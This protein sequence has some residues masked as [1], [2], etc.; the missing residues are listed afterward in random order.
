M[1]ELLIFPRLWIINEKLGLDGSEQFEASKEW[2]SINYSEMQTRGMPWGYDQLLF[3]VEI[4]ACHVA[5]HLFAFVHVGEGQKWE[6][7]TSHFRATTE[8]VWSEER[9]SSTW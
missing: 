4:R 8:W 9:R 2:K 1:F 7:Q 3:A 6:Q 5:G